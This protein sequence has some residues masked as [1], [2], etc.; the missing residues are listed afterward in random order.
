MKNDIKTRPEVQ[1]CTHGSHRVTGA[2]R[3]VLALSAERQS[4]LYAGAGRLSL[5]Q[6]S[7]SAH[8][9]EVTACPHGRYNKFV[10]PKAILGGHQ[11]MTTRDL[12]VRTALLDELRNVAKLC[13][14]PGE[15]AQIYT[16]IPGV[17]SPFVLLMP[18]G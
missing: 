16:E 11:V 6:Q 7:I 14:S 4:R 18:T 8:S 2:I 12:R 13:P 17:S 5:R 9:V 10:V 3:A 1:D 15:S